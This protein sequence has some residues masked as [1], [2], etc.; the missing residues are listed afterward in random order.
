MTESH[1]NEPTITALRAAAA[2]RL[3]AAG[4]LEAGR[5]AD[6]LLA[7][8]LGR[9]RA[10]ILAHPGA[11]VSAEQAATL[12]RAVERRAAGEPIQYITGWREFWRDRFRVN[13]AVLIPRPETELLVE[14][15]AEAMRGVASPRILDL[16][17]GSG[18]V[19]LSLLRELP[20]ARLVSTDRSMAALAVARG[21]AVRLGLAERA[22]FA[23]GD[24]LAFLRGAPA[25]VFRLIL[26]NPPYVSRTDWASLPVEVRDWEPRQALDGGADGLD[27]YRLWLPPALALL[28]RGGCLLMEFG[29]GQW[30]ALAQLLASSG[31]DAAMFPDLAGIPRI[32]RIIRP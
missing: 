9:E 31:C 10:F 20:G 27:F 16:A 13:P 19:G 18:C 11:A 3:K 17:A 29:H 30:P 23:C 26:A 14:K 7:W 32:F 22:V 12:A 2:R 24:G 25:G 1:P 4:R 6:T 5:D 15:G 21:N 8:V 28:R